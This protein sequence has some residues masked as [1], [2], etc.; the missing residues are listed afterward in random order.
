MH[1][2]SLLD[3]YGQRRCGR[4]KITAAM[5]ARMDGDQCR[6][7]SHE[8]SVVTDACNAYDW[9]GDARAHAWPYLRALHRVRDALWR[10]FTTADLSSGRDGIEIEVA[11]AGLDRE[12]SVTFQQTGHH[13][14]RI[15]A[16]V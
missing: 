12:A 4:P 8:E 6:A 5:A 16:R 15:A 11:K 14:R 3:P 1:R 9:E 10:G 7:T 13:R 2:S